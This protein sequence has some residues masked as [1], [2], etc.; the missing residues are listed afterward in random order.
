MRFKAQY[1][2]LIFSWWA[3]TQKRVVF[4]FMVGDGII[5]IGAVIVMFIY[6]V[7]WIFRGKGERE[8]RKI[9]KQM[10]SGKEMGLRIRSG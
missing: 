7:G 3:R 8:R 1:L 6:T 4:P 2:T 9:Q 10:E 5:L